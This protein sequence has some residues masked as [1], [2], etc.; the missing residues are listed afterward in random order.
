VSLTQTYTP[1]FYS[2]A[3]SPVDPRL[4]L[5]M[6]YWSVVLAGDASSG[7]L[8]MLLEFLGGDH[9]GPPGWYNLEFLA[10]RRGDTLVEPPFLSID[11]F[12]F[13]EG[14]G[15]YTRGYAVAVDRGGAA[16][17]TY[18]TMDQ[19]VVTPQHLGTRA[20]QG[21]AATMNLTW[22]TNTN[23]TSYS[24]YAHGYYWAPEG[25]MLPGG[26]QL[27]NAPLENLPPPPGGR[28]FYAA[29]RGG[30]DYVRQRRL[31]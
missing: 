14:V 26:V 23:G 22:G 20:A 17:R 9:P 24:V 21:T 11:G 18:S 3:G 16:G 12:G 4:P 8:Q 31:P 27:P 13:E 29:L 6:W 28:G 7:T 15:A 1:S 19:L 2:L 5:L 30:I 25:R 10:T